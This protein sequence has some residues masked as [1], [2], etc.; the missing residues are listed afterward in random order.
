MKGEI[1]DRPREIGRF[2]MLALMG[3]VVDVIATLAAVHLAYK[4]IL[5]AVVGSAIALA[6]ILWVSR[7]RSLIGRI[8]L[9]I[10]LA[11]GIIADVA[12]YALLL[13]GG[14]FGNTNPLLLALSLAGFGLNCAALFFAWAPASTLWLRTKPS[15]PRP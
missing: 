9:T 2:E 10:W 3:C 1:V 14:H 6:L 4:G 15:R 5:S 8:M 12:G 11:L 7:R 13:M